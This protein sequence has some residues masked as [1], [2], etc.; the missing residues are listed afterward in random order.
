MVMSCHQRRSTYTDLILTHF[1]D[2]FYCGHNFAVHASR[3]QLSTHPFMGHTLSM[4]A[5][6]RGRGRNG[7]AI[8]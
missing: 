2:D 6:L 3:V 5:A 8:L 1:V 7:E 4:T